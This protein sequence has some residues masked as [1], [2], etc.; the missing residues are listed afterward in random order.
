M[1]YG[2]RRPSDPGFVI[3][4]GL[5]NIVGAYSVVYAKR[6]PVSGSW[7]VVCWGK[8]YADQP[9]SWRIYWMK[10]ADWRCRFYVAQPLA[11]KQ[12][13]QHLTWESATNAAIEVFKAG[14]PEKATQKRGTRSDYQRERVYKWEREELLFTVE[15]EPSIDIGAAQALVS[16]IWRNEGFTS[17][18]PVVMTWRGRGGIANGHTIKMSSKAVSKRLTLHEL[19]HSMIKHLQAC[20]RHGPNWVGLYVRLLVR[21]SAANIDVLLASLKDTGIKVTEELT[22]CDSLIQWYKG[23]NT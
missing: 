8:L 4:A 12:A 23:K 11:N 13:L 15:A 22:D 17:D 2:R 9:E 20:D 16:S 10:R 3:P 6:H 18:A 21:Y 19:A 7:M 5:H 14:T 1:T